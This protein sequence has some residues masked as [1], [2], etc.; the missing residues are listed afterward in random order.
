MKWVTFAFA[1]FLTTALVIVGVLAYPDILGKAAVA[2]NDF[3]F[4]LFLGPFFV[5]LL[6]SWIGEKVL[7]R[8]L[9]KEQS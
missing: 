5:V 2:N 7:L 8:V 3:V 6:F 4:A 9:K 1:F